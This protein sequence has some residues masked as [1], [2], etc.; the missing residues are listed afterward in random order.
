MPRNQGGV[1]V[2]VQD[3]GPGRCIPY[4]GVSRLA[5]SAARFGI[6]LARDR[7]LIFLFMKE[8]SQIVLLSVCHVQVQQNCSEVLAAFIIN[9][10]TNTEQ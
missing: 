5:R 9:S 8:S 6:W 4:E 3:Q 1:G 10:L 2:G 7:H